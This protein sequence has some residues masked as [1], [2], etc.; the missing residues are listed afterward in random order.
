MGEGLAGA[1]RMLRTRRGTVPRRRG[2]VLKFKVGDKVVYPNHGIG[3]VK[4]IRDQQ[5]RG[6]TST[7]ISLE[8][9]ATDSVVMVPVR[10]SE[11]VGLRKLL[12]RTRVRQVLDKLRDAK[13]AVPNDWKGRYQENLDKMRTGDLEQVAEVLKNLTYLNEIKTLSYRERKMLDRA[14]ALVVSEL[15]EASHQPPNAVEKMVDEA[16]KESSGTESDH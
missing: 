5:I 9:L 6:E 4:E 1:R 3:V 8:I 13:V 16:M 11:A 15:A 12:P 7:F 10:N 2:Q 14:R